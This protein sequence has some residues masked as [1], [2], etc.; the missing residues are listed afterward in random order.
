MTRLVVLPRYGRLGASSRTRLWQYVPALQEAGF[1]VAIAPFF[2]DGYVRD[3]QSGRRRYG[4]IVRAYGTRLA[5]LRRA[6][7]AD[8]LWIEK[9]AFPWLPEWLERLLLPRN[10][11]IALDYD[12]A[13]FELYAGHR[14]RLVRRL[15]GEKHRR[16]MRRSALVTAG[17]RLLADYALEAGAPNV[18]QVPTVVDL[19]RY[20]PPNPAAPDSAGVRVC[21]IGQQSTAAFL[22]PLAPMFRELAADQRMRF[23]AIG[24]DTAAANLPMDSLAWSEASEAADIAACDI[25]IMPLPDTPFER[26]K[27][28][29][30]L[31][32][33]MACGLPVVASPVGANRDIVQHGVDGFL[34]DSEA[35]WRV[36][37]TRLAANSELRRRMGAAG[38]AKVESQYSLQVTAPR[39]VG[40]LGAVAAGPR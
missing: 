13:V 24:I 8:L 27:C 40:S 7:S 15:L 36:A 1:E 28:G 22:A 21:W 25:G 4:R 38:R 6:R 23:T 16:A 39:L 37:L 34:A 29:Y 19:E 20:P 5:A 11:P 32:Q 18:V 3:L 2:D 30:K 35:E 12:D 17:N 10:V 26:G 31:I 14:A 9:E 33:Y